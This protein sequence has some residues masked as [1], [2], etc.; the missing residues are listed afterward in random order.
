MA[1]MDGSFWAVKGGNKKVPEKLLEYSRAQ[2]IKEYVTK[3]TKNENSYTLFTSKN[4]NATYDYVV[5]AAPLAENQKVPITFTNISPSLNAG[6]YHQTVSTLVVG[7]LNR[8]KF[9]PLSDDGSMIL[10]ISDYEDEV[11]NSI[12]NVLGVN[13]DD[14]LTDSSK[15]WKVFSQK[16]LTEE[17]LYQLFDSTSEIKEVDWLAYP[18]YEVPTKPHNF[19]IADRLYHINA[20]E[21]AASAMEMI[22]IGSKNVALLI[23]KHIDE[24]ENRKKH[25]RSEL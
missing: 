3:I 13:G 23:K 18:H 2:L 19:R 10:V 20:I 22:C 25:S 6:K 15:V 21:W 7:E 1:G 17:Q 14:V 16:S 24:Q 5:Y 9:S 12:S 4:K 8:K 11:F